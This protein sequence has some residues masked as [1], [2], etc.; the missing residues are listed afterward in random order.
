MIAYCVQK[1]NTP[2]IV[3]PDTDQVLPLDRKRL[4]VFISVSPCFKG[5]IGTHHENLDVGDFGM[6]IATRDDAGDITVQDDTRWQ[7]LLETCLGAVSAEPA[8]GNLQVNQQ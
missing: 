3:I 6:R 7:A 1:D 4:E 5:W 8:P 2:M